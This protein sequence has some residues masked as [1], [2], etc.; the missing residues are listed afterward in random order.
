MSAS[1]KAKLIADAEQFGMEMA[2]QRHKFDAG[3]AFEAAS[4]VS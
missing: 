4:L 2:W 1:D 3:L